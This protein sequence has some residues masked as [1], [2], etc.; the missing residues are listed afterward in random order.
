MRYNLNPYDTHANERH[1]GLIGVM[2]ASFILHNLF[3]GLVV[4][5]PG[6][7]DFG[8]KDK[9]LDIMTVQ[10]V[11]NIE[12]PAPAAPQAPVNPD[13]KVPDVVQLPT[14]EPVIPQPTP[15]TEIQVPKTPVEAIPIKKEE[16]PPPEVK[17]VEEPPPK[18]QIPEK[19]PEPKP[20]P[21]KPK[22]KAPST[23]TQINNAI[24]DLQRKNAAA[25]EEA[26]INQSIA[27]IALDRG[28]STGVSS[29]PAAPNTRGQMIDPEKQ[30]Y[31]L[32]LLEIVRS[33]WMPPASSVAPNTVATFVIA[34]DP[35]G[36]V[37]GKNLREPSGNR[38]FDLSVEQAIN[39]SNFP[40]LPAAFG[41]KPDNPALRFTLSFLNKMG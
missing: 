4:L 6:F 12:P 30:R 19:P 31:Y 32:Q 25:E 26:A 16:T 17:R 39:R 33:N 9:P 21:P 7:F 27:N 22:A 41:G 5:A 10:L 34:I 38:E 24:R 20:P 2:I 28:R 18:V 29:Q 1:I 8:P 3:F 37:T 14:Q 35:S 13:L 23:D 11:G 36:R 40:P 15:I